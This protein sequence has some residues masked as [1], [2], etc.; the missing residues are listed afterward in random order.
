MDIYEVSHYKCIGVVVLGEFASDG[1]SFNLK[2]VTFSSL[3]SHMGIVLF[4]TPGCWL[5]GATHV[6]VDEPFCTRKV[7]L[8]SIMII[9]TAHAQ[10]TSWIY[11]RSRA[12][13]N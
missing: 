3:P 1:F 13:D 10:W 11:R 12:V 2:R 6:T 4:Q 9:T 7:T 5:P 8:C